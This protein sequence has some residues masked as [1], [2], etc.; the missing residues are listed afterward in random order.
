MNY[1]IVSLSPFLYLL[2]CLDGLEKTWVVVK[3]EVVNVGH[4]LLIGEHEGIFS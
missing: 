4:G 1:D 2:A 3:F